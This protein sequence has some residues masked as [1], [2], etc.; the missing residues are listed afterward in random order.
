MSHIVAVFLFCA[1]FWFL[2]VSFSDTW[3][4]FLAADVLSHNQWEFEKLWTQVVFGFCP[5][6]HTEWLTDLRHDVLLLTPPINLLGSH[7]LDYDS[8][9]R[10][11]P[12]INQPSTPLMREFN[13]ALFLAHVFPPEWSSWAAKWFMASCIFTG[14]LRQSFQFFIFWIHWQ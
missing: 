8:D 2:F 13:S 9:R 11:E 12:V 10:K 1:K 14:E 3:I 4:I 6:T 5:K 7:C